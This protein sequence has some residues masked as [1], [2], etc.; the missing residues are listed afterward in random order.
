M[1]SAGFAAVAAASGEPWRQRSTQLHFPP[2]GRTALH[3]QNLQGTKRNHPVCAGELTR[4]QGFPKKGHQHSGTLFIF[5]KRRVNKRQ[6]WI[7]LKN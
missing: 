4:G 2:S 7:F 1:E 3:H 6:G 5:N